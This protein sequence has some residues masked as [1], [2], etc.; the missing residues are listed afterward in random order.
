MISPD[1]TI[2]HYRVGYYKVDAN[3]GLEELDA[4]VEQALKA[5]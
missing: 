4:A 5:K 1:G 3:R 2:L